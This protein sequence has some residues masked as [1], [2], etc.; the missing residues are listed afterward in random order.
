MNGTHV[1]RTSR[2][3]RFRFAGWFAVG[4]MVMAAMAGPSAALSLSGAVYTSNQDGS[5]VNENLYAAKSDVYLTGGPCGQN[6]N[7]PAG[8]YYFQ[9]VQPAGGGA[10]LSTDA[11]G[12]RKFH[13][14]AD[15]YIKNVLNGSTH[16]TY[17]VNCDPPVTGITIQLIP[18]DNSSNGEYKLEVGT[19]ATVQACAGFNVNSTTFAFCQQVDQKSDNF[20]AGPQPPATDPPATEPPVTEPPVTQPPVTE[21]PVTEPPATQPPGEGGV[22]GETGTPK[23]TLPPTSTFD[24][25][26]GPSGDSWRIVMLGMA[27]FLAGILVLAPSG[28]GR[29]A[30]R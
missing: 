18:F 25:Q 11:I 24:G 22:E 20:K 21:P 2:T 27:A 6:S 19:A 23:V 4:L 28:R 15:G 26:A 7:L 16:A 14:D 3:G 13:I 5:S 17:A 9:V 29:R 10:L 30:R 8:D 1:R 12:N